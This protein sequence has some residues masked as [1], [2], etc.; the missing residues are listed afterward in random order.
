MPSGTQGA[1]LGL[2]ITLSKLAHAGTG[3]G[4]AE[5]PACLEMTAGWGGHAEARRWVQRKEGAAE[6]GR[7]GRLLA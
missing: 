3:A 1:V 6:G 4:V 2:A 7:S 5:L